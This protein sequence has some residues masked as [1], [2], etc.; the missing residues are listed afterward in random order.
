MFICC[1]YDF[2]LFNFLFENQS[3]RKT[4]NSLNI[5][6]TT[7]IMVIIRRSAMWF[8]GMVMIKFYLSKSSVNRFKETSLFTT[9]VGWV[10]L[11]L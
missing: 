4:K 3:D 9:R 7:D 2:L 1:E 8:I 6:I 5:D 10:G 11:L